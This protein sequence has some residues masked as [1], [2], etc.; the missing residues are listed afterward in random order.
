LIVAAYVSLFLAV[1]WEMQD[2]VATSVSLWMAVIGWLLICLST[3]GRNCA[4]YAL[5]KYHSIHIEIREQH[6]LARNGI[7]RFV[8]NPYYLSN[9]VEAAGLVLVA[10]GLLPVV[11]ASCVYFPLLIHRMLFEEAALAEKFGG[12]YE[13]YKRETPMIIPTISPAI[14]ASST[15]PKWRETSIGSKS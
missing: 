2:W 6:V 3:I 5:G 4:I 1:F 9:V 11:I 13:S 14:K 7:Y 12:L 10:N 8:R 15:K